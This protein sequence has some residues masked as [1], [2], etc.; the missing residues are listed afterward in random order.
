[1]SQMPLTTEFCNERRRHPDIR[2]ARRASTIASL[3]RV[4]SERDVS[5]GLRR[6]LLTQAQRLERLA[7]QRFE[8]I[9]EPIPLEGE[10]EETGEKLGK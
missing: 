5:K 8:S 1:M 9:Q 2:I 4:I 10:D 7:R 3:A 6:T